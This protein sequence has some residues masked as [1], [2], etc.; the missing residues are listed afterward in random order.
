MIRFLFWMFVFILA[1][2][3]SVYSQAQSDKLFGTDAAPSLY[4]TLSNTVTVDTTRSILFKYP[5]LLDGS[6]TISG[7][8]WLLSGTGETIT[9][10]MYLWNE[11]QWGPGHTLGT[12]SAP[13]SVGDS[14]SYDFKVAGTSWWTY[15]DGYKIHYS[16]P[17]SNTHQT[18]I[19]AR[20][21]IK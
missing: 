1:G 15:C 13:A 12:I 5:L 9:L 20:G 3:G 21:K 2:Y 16:V 10:T 19:K 18:R 7:K 4:D 6:L 11:D 8:V 14:V 17:G